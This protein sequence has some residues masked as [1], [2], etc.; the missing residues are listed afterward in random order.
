MK[1]SSL[2]SLGER[3]ALRVRLRPLDDEEIRSYIDFKL[4]AAGYGGR[5]IFSAAAMQRIMSLSQGIPRL[6]NVICDNAL[7]AACAASRDL[8][9]ADIIDEVAEDLQLGAPSGRAESAPEQLPEQQA[10]IPA[11]AEFEPGQPAVEG[12]GLDRVEDDFP[13]R[14]IASAPAISAEATPVNS[15]QPAEKIGRGSP[16]HSLWSR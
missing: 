8:I 15:G 5:A 16:S 2:R 6:I 7:L 12:I 11:V 13:R 14:D 1:T 10:P 3:V 9:G 4:A